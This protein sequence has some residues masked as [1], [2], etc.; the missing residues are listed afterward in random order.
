MNYSTTSHGNKIQN[1]V[2]DAG[3]A[4]SVSRKNVVVR[5]ATKAGPRGF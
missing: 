2:R 3:T 1:L 4:L 5:S